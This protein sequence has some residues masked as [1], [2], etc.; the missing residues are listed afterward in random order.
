VRVVSN[1][2]QSPG[3]ALSRD[4]FVRSLALASASWLGAVW[5]E[6]AKPGATKARLFFDLLG[7]TSDPLEISTGRPGINMSA[8]NRGMVAITWTSAAKGGSLHWGTIRLRPNGEAQTVETV[9]TVLETASLS[10]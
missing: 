2:E 7:N 1:D 6:T 5:S 8:R 3:P 10:Q 9:E 4:G